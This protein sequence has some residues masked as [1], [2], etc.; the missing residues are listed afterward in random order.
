MFVSKN[1]SLKFK[2]IDVVNC[3]L[4]NINKYLIKTALINFLDNLDFKDSLKL[5]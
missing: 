5:S 2:N 1:N 4:D 3:Q